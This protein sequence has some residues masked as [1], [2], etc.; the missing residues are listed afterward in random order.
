M[1]EGRSAPDAYGVDGEFWSE[2]NIVMLTRCPGCGVTPNARHED[3]C[4]VSRCPECGVQASQC[5]AHLDAGQGTWTGEW[6]GD[7]EC[8]EW[9]WWTTITHPSDKTE[10]VPDL[11]RLLLAAALG[12]VH[13]DKSG[14]RYHR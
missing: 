10:T 4:D 5:G 12:E 7:A 1:S 13:W 14:E 8:R 6:P 11:H 3:G 9:N 2:K